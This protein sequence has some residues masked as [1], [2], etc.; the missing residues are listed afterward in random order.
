MPVLPIGPVLPIRPVRPIGPLQRHG[1][2]DIR[3]LITCSGAALIK[4]V[5]GPPITEPFSVGHHIVPQSARAKVISLDALRGERTGDRVG[6]Y[7]PASGPGQ[8][9][10]AMID[11]SGGVRRGALRFGVAIAAS[12]CLHAALFAA[13]RRHAPDMT[14]G[15]GGQHLEAISI[16]IVASAA[17]ESL[18]ATPVAAT[19]GAAATLA[20]LPGQLAAMEQ[21]A[22]AAQVA[23]ARPPAVAAPPDA[24]LA[25]EA[26]PAP[27]E[28]AVAAIVKV[29]PMPVAL[30]TEPERAPDP[31]APDAEP[32][33]P[34]ATDADRDANPRPAQA[35]IIAGA[36]ASRADSATDTVDGSA[37]ASAGQLAQFAVDVRRALAGS[38]PRHGGGKGS[39]QV[40][41]GLDATGVIRFADVTRSSGFGRL[42][43]AALDAVRSVT[44]PT[45]PAGMTDA[46]RSYVVPFEFR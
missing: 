25:A 4:P 11:A 44:F 37:A 41:F 9:S 8:V 22:M 19:G 31:K 23:A 1:I 14:A 30:P 12:F 34:K 17:L 10:A 43:T 42:D 18:A 16:E 46:Q 38:R 39:V 15:G 13:L 5:V 24:R 3:G 36:A 6:P 33:D 21:A 29:E 40:R 27:A 2:I 32:P 26:S 35:A 20:P 28:V 7:R 45:P